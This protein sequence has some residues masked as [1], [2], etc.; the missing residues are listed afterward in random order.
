VAPPGSLFNYLLCAFL[1]AARFAVAAIGTVAAIAC[2]NSPGDR[3]REEKGHQARRDLLHKQFSYWFL[4][5][6]DERLA[7]HKLPRQKR[8][9]E[10][11][12]D[13]Q[14]VDSQQKAGCVQESIGFLLIHLYKAGSE[15]QNWHRQQRNIN[16]LDVFSNADLGFAYGKRAVL[17][18]F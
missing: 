3:E 10:S 13:P 12:L 2:K 16:V 18:G 6:L 9:G 8:N 5:V 14:N 4:C 11:S 15:K 1:S 17:D 7:A